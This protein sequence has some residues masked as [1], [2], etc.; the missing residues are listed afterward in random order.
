MKPWNT[1]GSEEQ[2]AVA[3]VLKSGVLSGFVGAWTEAFFG[4]R[5]VK[6]LESE[7]SA[8]FKIAESIAVNSATSG[9]YAAMGALDIKTGD[10]VIVTPTS[11]SASATAPLIYGGLPVFAD[12]LPGTMTLDPQSISK[13]ITPKTRAI[14][15]VN[16]FGQPALLDEIASIAAEHHL[17]IVE[18]NAQAP[19]A[20]YK[21]RYTG[22]IGDIGIFS[23]NCHKHI[24]CGEGG[25]VVTQ[26]KKLADRVRLIRNHA[27]SVAQG[28]GADDALSLVGYNFRMTEIEATIARCQLKKLPGITALKRAQAHQLTESLKNIKGLILPQEQKDCE[29]VYYTYPLRLD[30]KNSKLKRFEI[31]KAL[32]NEGIPVIESYVKPLYLLPLFDGPKGLCPVAEKL[33]EEELFYIPWC[34]Y[35]FTNDDIDKIAKAFQRILT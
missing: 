16:L 11:M 25:I 32:T 3:R 8:H 31:V 4:G 12:V 27:E 7:W 5:E 20:K 2:E 28:M 10:E 9:L 18:D 24:Q 34:A 14:I 15:V 22:T 26:S 30:A 35:D 17:Y 21:G 29:G 1:I 19:G 23:L 6:A 13:K 33:Y